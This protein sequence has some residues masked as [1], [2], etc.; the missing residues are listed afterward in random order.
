MAVGAS[1][2]IN[3][4]SKPP[5]P[6]TANDVNQANGLAGAGIGLLFAS[7][8][9]LVLATFISVLRSRGMVES[10]ERAVGHGMT[11]LLAVVAAIP[12]LGIRVVASFVYYVGK[13]SQLSPV[14]GNTGLVVGLE[15]VEEIIVTLV[16]IAAGTVTQNIGKPLRRDRSS[17]P[18]SSRAEGAR[19]TPS[20][21]L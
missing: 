5:G 10:E 11:L 6:T 8:I 12:F 4:E 17:L 7:W 18:L 9:A 15:T 2:L 1:N 21:G 14:G 19:R 20:S 16:F 13:Q 3:A